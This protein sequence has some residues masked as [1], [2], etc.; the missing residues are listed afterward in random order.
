MDFFTR[1][2]INLLECSY[3]FIFI[4]SK[5][6]CSSTELIFIRMFRENLAAYYASKYCTII[7]CYRNTKINKSGMARIYTMSFTV[8]LFTSLFAFWTTSRQVYTELSEVIAVAY[9]FTI[10]SD[11]YCSESCTFSSVRHN[12]FELI[13][14]TEILYFHKT[15]PPVVLFIVK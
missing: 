2:Y 11:S 10:R 9:I 14:I 3:I 7:Q 8:T 4:N 12:L 15:T 1:L 13:H 6:S 5:L